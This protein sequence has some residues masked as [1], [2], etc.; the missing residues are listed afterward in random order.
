MVQFYPWSKYYFPLFLTHYHTL[1]QPNTKGNN[2]Q[3]KDKIEP[4]QINLYLRYQ[5]NK[6][7]LLLFYTDIPS[8][9]CQE[10]RF[11]RSSHVKLTM[12]FFS[13]NLNK[14]ILSYGYMINHA[15]RSK[16]KK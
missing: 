8:R 7:T 14:I 4:P 15:S 10:S 11:R 1:P 6:E 13:S 2:I 5:E 9:K 12:L 16:K 3:T